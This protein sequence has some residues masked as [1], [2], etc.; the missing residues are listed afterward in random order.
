MDKKLRAK[1]RKDF[2][3]DNNIKRE[4]ESP[5]K[6]KGKELKLHKK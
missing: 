1:L 4:D 3:K 5:K 2:E 6:K